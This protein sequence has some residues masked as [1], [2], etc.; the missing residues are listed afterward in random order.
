MAGVPYKIFIP[1][2]K[3]QI[4]VVARDLRNLQDILCA[5]LHLAPGFQVALEDGTLVC[6]ED[7]FKVLPPQTKLVVLENTEQSQ[8]V[9]STAGLWG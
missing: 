2:W 6:E 8:T 5:K 4:G 3:K 9:S 1:K 7:Y